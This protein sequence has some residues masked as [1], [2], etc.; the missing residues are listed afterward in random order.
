MTCRAIL[1]GRVSRGDRQQDP[2]SQLQA[3]RAWAVQRSWRVVAEETDRI[4]CDPKRRRKD[5]PGLVR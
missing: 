3:L 1:L 2:E 5:P 4:T